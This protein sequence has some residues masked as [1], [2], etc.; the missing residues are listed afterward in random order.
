M[1]SYSY[2]IFIYQ[3]SIYRNKPI[4]GAAPAE[5][6]P[7][8]Y[9]DPDDVPAW[10]ALVS[11]VAAKTQELI[12]GSVHGYFQQICQ[13]FIFSLLRNEI[14]DA[15]MEFESMKTTIQRCRHALL[16]VV[17]VGDKYRAAEQVEREI[18]QVICCFDDIMCHLLVGKAELFDMYSSKQLMYQFLV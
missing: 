9:P 17:R 8:A 2:I 11:Q 10:M 4:L 12:K 1:F 13:R 7:S 15:T 18:D 6:P 5:A 14:D 3:L 16:Q